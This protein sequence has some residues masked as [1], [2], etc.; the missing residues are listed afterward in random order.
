MIGNFEDIDVAALAADALE[1]AED[2]GEFDFRETW[3]AVRTAVSPL[4]VAKESVVLSAEL[5]KIAVGASDI[6]PEKRDWRFNDDAWESNAFYKRLG[7]SYLAFCK[8]AKNIVNDDADWRTR[9][10]AKFALEV[11]TSALAPTNTLLGN[12]AALKK[13]FD[14]NGKSLVRG[15]KNFASD[16]RHNGGMP[17]MVDSSPFTKGDNI[18]ATPGAVVFRN[19]VLELL[20]YAPQTDSVY[21][22]PTLL[23][24]PQI[25]KYYFTDLAPGRSLVEY[26]MQQ[27]V[28]M[29][30]A[31][32][33]NPQNEQGDWDLDTYVSALLEAI[34][35]INSI[36]GRKKVNTIGFCAGGITM[37]AMLAC[38]AASNDKRVNA[39]SYAVTLLDW[40]TPSM[41]GMLHSKKLI[42]H[43]RRKSRRK[44][45]ISGQDLGS[46]F[47]WFR[48]NEL[49]WNYWVNNYLMG[50]APPSFDILAWNA[51]STNLPASLHAQFL[52]MFMDNAMKVAGEIQVLG[53]PVD[54]SKITADAFVVG[55]IDDHLTPWKGCYE[56]TQLLGGNSTFVL[57]NAGHIAALVNPPGNPKASYL[58]G[59]KP[60][61]DPVDWLN[62]A[63][64]HTGSWWEHWSAW[65][66][67]RSGDKI[68]AP[69]SLGNKRF[70]ELDPAPGTYIDG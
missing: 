66:G 59:P 68:D 25:N 28:Q 19:E 7:Q 69:A 60:G 61:E 52:D 23:I 63:K 2:V 40:S 53:E 20:Q 9:E 43:A 29:Y 45:I 21:A 46:V 38:M 62:N 70:P 32:W 18:A 13:A 8:G 22:I 15:L 26:S 35:A 42:N 57:S 58:A 4:A 14:T 5:V 27:G 67:E 10:R 39:I 37:S 36:T 54:L 50:E 17:S 51:D 49:V 12:P 24:P 56:T 47:A 3:K 41:M 33:R 44:G 11:T 30:V 34:D 65:V 1:A 64:K 31:S 16:V 6:G 48:P 55:A